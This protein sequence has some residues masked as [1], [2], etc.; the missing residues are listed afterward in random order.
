MITLEDYYM[1][2]DKLYPNLLTPQ[3]RTNAQLTVNKTNLLLVEMENDGIVPAF[4]QVTKT[5]VA[6][7]WRPPEVNDRTANSGK[8]SKHITCQGVDI[9]D[10]LDRRCAAWILK[11]RHV[12]ITFGLYMEDPQWTYRTSME[13]AP[14]PWFHVQTVAPGSGNRIFIPS[15][16]PPLGAPL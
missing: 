14:D 6:S 10:H 11:N 13:K 4:D 2:R 3:L 1:G 12:L 16:A 8:T 7:G 5:H 15:S 9:Q